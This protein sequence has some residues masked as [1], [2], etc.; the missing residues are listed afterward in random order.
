GI[1]ASREGVFEPISKTC[2]WS[3]VPDDRELDGWRRLHIRFSARDDGKDI[4]IWDPRFSVQEED[5]EYEAA[6]ILVEEGLEVLHYYWPDGSQD[7]TYRKGSNNPYNGLFYYKNR[8]K[9]TYILKRAL[10]DHVPTGIGVT[11]PEFGILPY[12][13]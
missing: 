7:V 11:E 10:E 1:F 5:E 4:L 9:R 13:D 8:E 3:Q 6:G 12:A 2:Y